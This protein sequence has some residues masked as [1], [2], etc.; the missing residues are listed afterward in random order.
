M[1][2]TQE[3][4]QI[5]NRIGLVNGSLTIN[6]YDDAEENIT[7]CINPKNWNIE[8]N[9]KTGYEPI[10]DRRQKAYARKKKIKDGK[11]Q[12]LEDI[13]YHELGHW[14]LPFTSGFGCPYDD[15]HHDLIKEAVKQGLPEEKQAQAHYVANAF[16]DLFNNTRCREFT[17]NFAGQV[18]FFDEQGTKLQ[19][20]GY[21]PFYEAFVKLN[22]LLWGDNI[23]KALVKRHFKNDRKVDSAV[24]EAVRELDLSEKEDITQRLFDKRKWPEMAEK[25]A[26]ILAPLL[27]EAPKE[28]LSAYQS[29]NGN[30][31]QEKGDKE[32]AGNG[33]EAKLPTKEGK[34]NVAYQRYKNG[35]GLSPNIET[36]EQLDLLYRQLARA[37]PVRVEAMTREQ[38]MA[39]APLN[40][41]PFDDEKDDIRRVKPTKLYLV[42]GEVTLGYQRMPLTITGKSKIQKRDFP[43][44]KMVV[45]DSSGS[46]KDGIDG[47]AGDKTFIPWGDR[48]KYH[49]A[50]L[51]FYGIEQFLQAQGIAQYI[52]HGL[53]LFSSSTRY[54][55]SKFT[56]LHRLRKLALSPE[57]GNTR[58]DASTLAN[59]LKGRES[60]VLSISD[61][62]VENW[63]SA[64]PQLLELAKNNSYGHI[65]IGSRN[66]FSGDL[67]SAGLPVFYVGSG[68]ELS[69]LMVNIAEDSYKRFTKK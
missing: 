16:E 55:E 37:I 34:E 56:D 23:D 51:G 63:A 61:G 49:Y 7:A 42:D 59:A 67:E 40:Y 62:E 15:Y 12:M 46:M 20:K 19:G 45:L 22:M 43:D 5:K 52:G 48:S 44:F 14:E 29:P 58:L 30:D 33:I 53:S 57:F 8:F 36:F 21:T 28:R 66:G 35:N 27:D 10:Q 38:S 69:K 17:G 26:R 3:L 11:R 60:F 65:Q 2:L 54:E 24:A 50:L 13:L 6:E 32:S 1:T 25:F 47:N 64:K 41:R 9:L 39:I 18:L 31:G 68:D 4:N